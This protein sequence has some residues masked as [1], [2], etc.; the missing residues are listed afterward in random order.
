MPLFP[1]YL[2]CRSD[3]SNQHKVV[4]APW[5]VRIV[6]AGREPVPVP[7]TEIDT[8]QILVRTSESL[9]PWP[10]VHLGDRVLIQAG[11]FK[12]AVGQVLHIKG[13]LKLIVSINILQRSAAVELSS[14]V[15]TPLIPA[16]YWL[17][18][19]SV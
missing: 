1:G 18:A 19:N 14:E 12:G 9:Q 3:R 4:T 2:F 5:V 16:P 11:V 8:L 13:K 10:Y 6:S 17:H 15:V 7:D